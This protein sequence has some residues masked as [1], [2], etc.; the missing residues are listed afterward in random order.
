[1]S[2]TSAVQAQA[3]A[4]VAMSPNLGMGMGLGLP[5]Q[6]EQLRGASNP[7]NNKAH[8]RY[9]NNNKAKEVSGPDQVFKKE[10]G[11]IKENF[12]KTNL[13]WKLEIL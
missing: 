13:A 1:M 11:N 7:S 5:L 4:T 8:K 6:P 12:L 9:N 3:Q 2:Y 10:V